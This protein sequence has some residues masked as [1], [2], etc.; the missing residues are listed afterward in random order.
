MYQ[1]IIPAQKVK[2][3]IDAESYQILLAICQAANKTP[4]QLIRMLTGKYK[5]MS[6]IER[7]FMINFLR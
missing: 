4:E 2:V 7:K 6:Y 5:Q 3:E 1:Q